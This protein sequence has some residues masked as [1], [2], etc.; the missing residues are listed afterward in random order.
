MVKGKPPELHKH[1]H[2]NLTG[3]TI[4]TS[5]QHLHHQRMDSP[6]G[7]PGDQVIAI[8][9]GASNFQD[10]HT[11]NQRQPRMQNTYAS[12]TECIL[13]NL[14]MTVGDPSSGCFANAPWRAFTWT[15]GL[16]QETHTE[17]WGTLHAAVQESLELAEAVDIQVLPGLQRLW[18]KHD[19]NIQG[20]ANHFVNAPWN[21]SQSRAF[22]YRYAEIKAGGYLADHVQVPLLVDFPQDW[23]EKIMLQT[24]MNGW[25]NEGLGQY[26]LDDKAILV[27]HIT[28]NTTLDGVAT[29]H[30]KIL[31]PYGTF[32]VPRSM[33]GFARA[34][35]EF[36]PAALIC[37]RGPNHE[38]G[39]YFAILIYR[40]L[41]WLADDGKAPVHLPHL[42]P[43]LASQ[44]VQ[45][46]AV[47]IAT[48]STTQQVI[49]RLP[50]PE[51]PDF[52]PPL[53]PSPEKRPRLQQT[54]CKIHY[55]NITN[56]GRQVIDWYWTRDSEPYILVE[57]HLDPQQHVNKLASTTPYGAAQLLE[58]QRGPTVTI[59]APM[60]AYWSLEINPVA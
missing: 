46:W 43:Q 23:P 4:L 32:T 24:L 47:H 18:K 44:A 27:T 2:P 17:P 7:A 13:Q 29:K 60:E 57:T 31:N 55:A 21:L 22:H 36:V 30:K 58:S 51:E 45:I 6:A 37:H 1:R 12:T 53:H 40:D 56:F 25:A 5:F 50:L 54:H 16:L 39:H 41:M 8:K 20:D 10:D 52:D 33:D 35:T 9:G 19:L 11:G 28:R 26:L 3:C 49:Q 15:C 42:T 14:S 38:A 59:Q 48:F 34:S